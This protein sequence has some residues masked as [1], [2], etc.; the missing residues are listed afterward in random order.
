VKTYYDR[1]WFTAEKKF[2]RVIELNP[3]NATAHHFY[4]TALRN[5]GQFAAAI[6]QGKRALELDPLS[7][8]H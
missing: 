2:R 5:M 6:A 3:G 4:G 8:I 7:L 1:D